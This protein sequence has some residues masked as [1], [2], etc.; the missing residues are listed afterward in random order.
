M[1]IC[2]VRESALGEGGIGKRHK[3]SCRLCFQLLFGE[4][5]K[6]HVKFLREHNRI[7]EY[8]D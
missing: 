3:G 7:L 1:N 2:F 6:V 4:S 8:R 5:V